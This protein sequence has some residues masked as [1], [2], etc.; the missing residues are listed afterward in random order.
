MSEHTRRQHC[1]PVWSALLC[2]LD[3]AVGALCDALQPDGATAEP[4]EP[5]RGRA[6]GPRAAR[7]ASLCRLAREWVAA[8]RG[9]R[10]PPGDLGA[11]L[12]AVSPLLGEL[13]LPCTRALKPATRRALLEEVSELIAAV[14]LVDTPATDAAVAAAS[15][16]AA[17]EEPG[18]GVLRQA[19]ALLHALFG[20][21]LSSGGAGADDDAAELLPLRF[22]LRLAGWRR[23]GEAVLPLLLARCDALAPRAPRAVRA[24]LFGL[25]RAQPPPPPVQ[26]PAECA[27]L[28]IDAL[29]APARPSAPVSTGRE[30]WEAASALACCAP[31]PTAVAERCRVAL[32]S[33]LA[34]PH[35]AARAAGHEMAA[36]AAA[37]LNALVAS[38]PS[39]SVSASKKARRRSAAAADAAADEGPR[40]LLRLGVAALRAHLNQAQPSREAQGGAGGGAGFAAATG[41]SVALLQ[42]CAAAARTLSAAGG[43]GVGGGAAALSEPLSALW[44][45]LLPSLSHGGAA[46]RGAALDLLSELERLG[47]AAADGAAAAAAEKGST[48]RMLELCL[49]LE[50]SPQAPT[51]RQ[52]VLDAE[53]LT[54]LATSGGAMPPHA[55]RALAYYS[56]GVL[57]IRFA[58][59]WAHAPPLLQAIARS[60]PTT[61]WP[62]VVDAVASARRSLGIGGGGEQGGGGAVGGGADAPEDAA[63]EEG[64]VPEGV[65]ALWAE[66]QSAWAEVTSPPA[67]ETEVSHL[68]TQLLKTLAA[69]GPLHG[70]AVRHAG[71][72]MPHWHELARDQLRLAAVDVPADS[73]AIPDADADAEADA[74]AA[75]SSTSR[76]AASGGKKLLAEW[77]RFF[78]AVEAPRRLPSADALYGEASALV[79]HPL[80]A[81]QTLALDVLARWGQEP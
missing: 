57:R 78:A 79:G 77:L 39:P 67:V 52:L 5:P 47:V 12:G 71:D 56:L 30:A 38:T 66:V 31:L 37:A 42:A 15:V 16:M 3:E 63:A 32:R 26:L 6:A 48:A 68:A 18:A 51:S 34:T 28:L 44:D 36:V 70:L 59:A 21:A 9:S 2:S 17:S 41:P 14:L 29:E 60:Q 81:V 45:A 13:V 40:Q 20:D 33:L 1:G 72:L 53:A 58:R 24:L 27:A 74:E 43:G 22:G 10:V 35:P 50:A 11:L 73:D 54:R 23:F 19:E 49:A 69:S 62:L 7:V 8:R 64:S 65:A 55:T 61:L 80:P 25:S 75:A 46:V 4:A 76:R